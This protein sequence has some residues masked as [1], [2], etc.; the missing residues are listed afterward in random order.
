MP[1]A[2]K[3]FMRCEQSTRVW[4]MGFHYSSLVQV[5]KTLLEITDSN[6][7]KIKSPQNT[8]CWT[9]QVPTQNQ[10]QIFMTER[11]LKGKS[12]M[13]SNPSQQ[14]MH[15]LQSHFSNDNSR[16]KKKSVSCTFCFTHTKIPNDSLAQELCKR[17]KFRGWAEKFWAA[18]T[19]KDNCAEH[20]R[21][22]DIPGAKK[23]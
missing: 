22:L 13:L 11:L 16:I 19:C 7:P 6:L 1:S 12:R 18:M 15:H 4:F 5:K 8:R 20:R 21:K 2:P 14:L 23:D 10:L 9:E 3:W 17:Q